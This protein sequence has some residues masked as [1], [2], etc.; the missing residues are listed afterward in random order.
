MIQKQLRR[1]KVPLRSVRDHD[2]AGL[3]GDAIRSETMKTLTEFDGFTLKRGLQKLAELEKE[4]KTA[5]E[6]PALI[7][8]SFKYEG[9]KLKF[10]QV[11]LEMAKARGFDGESSRVKRV[12][13]MTLL[14]TE[15][16]PQGSEKREEQTYV[17]ELFPAPPQERKKGRGRFDGDR[18]GG[19]GKGKGG[20]GGKRGERGGRGGDRSERRA[21]NKDG[22]PPRQ[23]RPQTPSKPL[24]IPKPRA[25]PTDAP[26]AS[27]SESAVSTA[28]SSESSGSSAS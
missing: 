11:A 9:D 17:L 16:A 12:V 18:K 28:A 2:I 7:T 24:V 13:V 4:G 3:Y 27:T 25:L 26:A 19:R 10:F 20:R 8:E 1:V 22:R 6:I 23:P 15:K 5:E 21:Q 14:E